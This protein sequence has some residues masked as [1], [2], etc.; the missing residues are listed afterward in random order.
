[1]NLRKLKKSMYK[2]PFELPAKERDSKGALL[3]TPKQRKAVA[4]TIRTSP[5]NLR[6]RVK[7]TNSISPSP[8]TNI[9]PL[10]G[11][12]SMEDFV[13]KRAKKY[14]VAIKGYSSPTPS[15]ETNTCRP[16]L[17]SPTF[18]ES[19]L[20]SKNPLRTTHLILTP[21]PGPSTHQNHLRLTPQPKAP[22]SNSNTKGKGRE[23]ATRIGNSP[24]PNLKHILF[25]IE[26]V[27]I[28][29]EVLNANVATHSQERRRLLAL[30]DSIM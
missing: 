23:V 24:N 1:M 5:Y 18:L 28:K 6:S 20:S 25:Q 13:A 16:L 9:E 11:N 30:L 14:A 29:L 17:F 2:D 12:L 8:S 19:S 4:I 21:T 26:Q 7:C 22:A 15:V 27:D 3:R 10:C